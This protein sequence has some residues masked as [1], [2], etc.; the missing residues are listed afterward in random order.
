MQLQLNQFN[1]LLKESAVYIVGLT[2]WKKS[3]NVHVPSYHIHRR[4]T[5]AKPMGLLL[6]RYYTSVHNQ[7]PLQLQHEMHHEINIHSMSTT[8]PHHHL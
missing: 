7:T 3:G 2:V 6:D 5:R 4:T 8:L 1:E